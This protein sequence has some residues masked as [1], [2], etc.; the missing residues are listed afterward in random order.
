MAIVF[1][2][3]APNLVTNVGLFLIALGNLKGQAT[4]EW[5]L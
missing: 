2:Y 4:T 1:F 5:G 3:Y